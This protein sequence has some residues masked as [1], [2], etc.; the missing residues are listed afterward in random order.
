MAG[1]DERASLNI[2]H[3]FRAPVGGLF[4]HVVDV[5]RGQAAR[6]H[7]V[8]LIADSTT[9]GAQAEATL[10]ALAREL[11]FGVTRIPMSRHIGV[12]DIPAVPHVARRASDIAADVI[13]GHGG[14]GGAYARLARSS[15]AIRVYTPHGGS[16]HYRWVSPIGFVYLSLERVAWPCKTLSHRPLAPLGTDL[17]VA[18]AQV[19]WRALPALTMDE[20]GDG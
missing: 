8:G 6:G 17:V 11:A 12:S 19:Q 20:P 18:R 3:V 10:E 1:G 5:A 14:K 4:R 15:H 13:H 7:R 16:L 2:L 9:G